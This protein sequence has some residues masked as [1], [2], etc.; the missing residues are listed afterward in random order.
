[1]TLL[2][3]DL[4]FLRT[5]IG[6]SDCKLWLLSLPR[7]AQHRTTLASAARPKTFAFVT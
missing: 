5:H 6:C 7:S 1:M 4:V 3:F 2:G